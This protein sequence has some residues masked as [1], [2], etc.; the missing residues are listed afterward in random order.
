MSGVSDYYVKIAFMDKEMKE[1]DFQ[2]EFDQHDVTGRHAISLKCILL[3]LVSK[4]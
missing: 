3:P 4:N 1:V 2:V